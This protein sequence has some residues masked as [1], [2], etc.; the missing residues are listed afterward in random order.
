MCEWVDDVIV[1]VHVRARVEKREAWAS[2]VIEMSMYEWVDDVIVIVHVRARVHVG[3]E[4]REEEKRNKNRTM[5]E[6]E[7]RKKD[8]LFLII[9]QTHLGSDGGYIAVGF[10]F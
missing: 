10:F 5:G 9:F 6:K 7:K 8:H 1:I 3:E 4:R 2:S